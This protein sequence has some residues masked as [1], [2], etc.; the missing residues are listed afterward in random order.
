MKK[1][2]TIK[3]NINKYKYL[4]YTITGV[5][6]SISLYIISFIWAYNHT[7]HIH[8]PKRQDIEAFSHSDSAFYEGGLKTIDSNFV[9]ELIIPQIDKLPWLKISL[10]FSQHYQGLFIDSSIQ[11]NSLYLK[12]GFSFDIAIQYTYIWFIIIITFI[13]L[14]LLFLYHYV[15]T[16]FFLLF[17]IKI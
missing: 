1:M 5:L 14:I 13:I 7:A 17:I 10:Y 3:N 6:I 11:F 9:Y 15:K 2:V 4:I 12:Y 16:F 8:I